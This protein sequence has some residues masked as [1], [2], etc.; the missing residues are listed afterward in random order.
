MSRASVLTPARPG[1][2]SAA[3]LTP[4]QLE[5]AHALAE[6]LIA[7]FQHFPPVTVQSA[8]GNDRSQE[9]TPKPAVPA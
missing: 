2:A 5:L 9:A 7:D 8:G 1:P 6:L 4:R 3:G